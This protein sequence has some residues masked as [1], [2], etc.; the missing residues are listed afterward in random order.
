[1]EPTDSETAAAVL[2][3]L[4]C[5]GYRV[6]ARWV[7]CAEKRGQRFVVIA[8][9]RNLDTLDAASELLRL[10]QKGGGLSLPSD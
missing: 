7:L 2:G 8:D 3:I 6:K 9:G 4:E 5:L 10:T 1:M